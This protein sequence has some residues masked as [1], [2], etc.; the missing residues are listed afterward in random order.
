MSSLDR[1][2]SESDRAVLREMFGPMADNAIA[3]LKVSRA[4]NFEVVGG[5]V[6]GRGPSDAAVAAEAEEA[7]VP[8]APAE[9]EPEVTPEPAAPEEPAE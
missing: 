1:L 3:L 4:G 9:P 8:D 5:R 6:Y 7:A 2:V